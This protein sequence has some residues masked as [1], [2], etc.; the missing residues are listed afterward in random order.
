MQVLDIHWFAIE[1]ANN[2]IIVWIR[3]QIQR[4]STWLFVSP[5]MLIPVP[6]PIFID[7]YIYIYIWFL[8]FFCVLHLCL[9]P[10]FSCYWFSG[11]FRK[12]SEKQ[13]L[14]KQCLVAKQ[15]PVMLGWRRSCAI[16]VGPWAKH[17]GILGNLELDHGKWWKMIIA[18]AVID[19]WKWN[20]AD[21]YGYSTYFRMVVPGHLWYIS[22]SM[23]NLTWPARK[24]RDPAVLKY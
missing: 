4:D 8:V 15:A 13:E 3:I 23:E 6:W 11:P 20:M 18:I 9:H 1:P 14:R 21:I 5:T 17:L 24:I 2:K 10:S 12:S 16:E 22:V 19:L 7:I